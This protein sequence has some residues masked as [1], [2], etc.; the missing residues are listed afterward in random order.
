MSKEYTAPLPSIA[1]TTNDEDEHP[2]I[3]V[4]NYLTSSKLGL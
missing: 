4:M 2:E 3:P 1:T